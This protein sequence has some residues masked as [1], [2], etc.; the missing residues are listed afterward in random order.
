M[1]DGD[2]YHRVQA[3]WLAGVLASLPAGYHVQPNQVA[4]LAVLDEAGEYVGVI[5]LGS[6]ELTW[7]VAP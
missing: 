6:E 4:N 3:S 5:E 2:K 7:F 1:I